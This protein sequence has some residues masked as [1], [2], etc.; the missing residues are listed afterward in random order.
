MADASSRFGL[1]YLQPGQA[2]KEIFHNEA[3]TTVDTL[4]HAAAESAGDDVPPITPTVGQCWIVG[5]S[6]SGAWAGHAGALAA[7]SEGGWRFAVPTEGMSVWLRDVELWARRGASAW[8]IGDIPAQSVSVAGLQI[9]GAQQP[10]VADPSGGATVDAQARTAL[11]ALL[12]AA[13]AHGL[14]AT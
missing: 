2:Q 4:L 8:I 9:V 5:S 10:A 3:L 6:P 14:I 13:R 11:S 7:W 12:A 1:P